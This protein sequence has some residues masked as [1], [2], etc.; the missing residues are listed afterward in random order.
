METAI[1][2]KGS[3]VDIKSILL[4]ITALAFIYFVPAL[5][6]L[7][8]FPIY[9]FEPMRIMLVLSL[10]HSGRINNYAVALTLPLFSFLISSHPV[11]MKTMLIAFEL[12]LNVALFYYLSKK[13]K[14][15]FFAMLISIVLSKMAYYLVKYFMISF[16]AIQGELVTTPFIYQIATT[17]VFSI[18]IYFVIG[19][20]Q[21]RA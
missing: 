6:H 16:G 21:K 19:N 17:M 9:L 13:L 10:A 5:S 8:N 11:V 15:S 3:K 4:D 18:Y 20:K 7:L 2:L 1:A 12:C 14:N